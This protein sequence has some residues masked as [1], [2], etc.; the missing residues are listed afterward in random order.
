M[1]LGGSTIFRASAT[2]R[3]LGLAAAVAA[4]G[5]G[6]SACVSLFPKTPPVQLYAFG[7]LP[8]P[9]AGPTAPGAVGVVLGGTTMPAA[10]VGD[11]I[12]TVT[13]QDVAYIAGARWVV[14]AGAMIQGDAERAFEA[15]GRRVRLLHRGD[16]GGAVALLHLDVGDFEARYDTPG[17]APTVVVSL[18]ASLTRPGGALIAAQTFTARQPA[19]DNRV[20]P[21][22]AAYD[23]AVIEVLGQVVAWTEGNAPPPP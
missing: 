15:K 14:P 19:A 6:L 18:R 7:Q 21:I 20:G 5:L 22:V 2:L 23:K 17:A 9:P 13:G 10:A 4:S 3:R 12:L 8:P 16:V 11:Q 1:S